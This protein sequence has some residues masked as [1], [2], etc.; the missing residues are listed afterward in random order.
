MEFT[1]QKAIGTGLQEGVVV[2]LRGAVGGLERV[3]VVN[4]LPRVIV[5][6]DLAWAAQSLRDGNIVHIFA[7]DENTLRSRYVTAG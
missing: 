5:Y 2:A 6:N 7:A 4:T 3:A 1:D